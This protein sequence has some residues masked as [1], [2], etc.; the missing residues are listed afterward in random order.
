MQ[1]CRASRCDSSAASSPQLCGADGG[2]AL[3]LWERCTCSIL[4]TDFGIKL[5]LLGWDHQATDKMVSAHFLL[6]ITVSV[7]GTFVDSLNQNWQ[8][9]AVHFGT[10]PLAALRN[11]GSSHTGPWQ[12]SRQWC[13]LASIAC[14]QVRSAPNTPISH[15]VVPRA[16]QS[17]TTSSL[18]WRGSTLH[19][20][21]DVFR[22]G[23][24]A[25]WILRLFYV[26][27]S[28]DTNLR[29]WALALPLT[30]PLPSAAAWGKQTDFRSPDSYGTFNL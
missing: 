20:Q 29:N 27:V 4:P 24:P 2:A 11:T 5:I 21:P 23:M 18:S 7:A 1:H 15:F 6:Q 25:C 28:R 22:S 9:L 8:H 10:S 19:T 3:G 12:S 17:P 30:K 26:M 16:S 13:F 14:Q